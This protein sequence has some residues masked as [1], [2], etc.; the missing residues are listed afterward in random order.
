MGHRSLLVIFVI[1]LVAA[2]AAILVVGSEDSV[3]VVEYTNNDDS[4]DAIWLEPPVDL[5][6]VH[7]WNRQGPDNN[8]DWW[9][10]NASSGR[11]NWSLP[12]A[13]GVDE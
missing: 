12:S 9:M 6:E 5:D 8:E 3:A 7:M 1:A 11:S 13:S 2:L 10:F 4:A